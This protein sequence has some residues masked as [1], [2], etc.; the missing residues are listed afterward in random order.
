MPRVVDKK[1]D[2]RNLT[3]KP[4]YAASG[5]GLIAC[6]KDAARKQDM[7]RGRFP[8]MCNQSPACGQDCAGAGESVERGDI[9][10]DPPEAPG[11]FGEGGER[12][13]DLSEGRREGPG[14]LA[15]VSP[16]HRTGALGCRESGERSLPWGFGGCGASPM[17]RAAAPGLGLRPSER[18]AR[19]IGRRTIA[20]AV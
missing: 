4:R 1:N 18:T 14:R 2:A 9:P 15:K 6:V 3:N 19:A 20:R 17:R 12:L 7:R 5:R 13:F 11:E 10:L 8:H 16:V